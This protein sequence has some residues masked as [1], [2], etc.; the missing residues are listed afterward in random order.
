[1][2][3]MDF[4]NSHLTRLYCILKVKIK[5]FLNTSLLFLKRRSG[6]EEIVPQIF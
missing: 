6:R 4:D 2:K 1:M 3:S 5:V